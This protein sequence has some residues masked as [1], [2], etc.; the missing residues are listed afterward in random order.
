MYVLEIEDLSDDSFLIVC[1]KESAKVFMWKGSDFEEKEMV[2]FI[3][4]QTLQNFIDSALLNYFD[5]NMLD[6]LEFVT[7]KP[8]EETEEFLQFF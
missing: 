5:E 2:A 4:T 7:E 3:F 6:D 1:V 8:H